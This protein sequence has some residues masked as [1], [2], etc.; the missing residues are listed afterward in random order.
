[1]ACILGRLQPQK[2]ALSPFARATDGVWLCNRRLRRMDPDFR[3][4]DE[5]GPIRCAMTLISRAR[6]AAQRP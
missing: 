5:P 4:D 3:Q 6:Y 1:M 2:L